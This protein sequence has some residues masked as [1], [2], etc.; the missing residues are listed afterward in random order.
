MTSVVNQKKR[1]KRFI[2]R[3]H[4]SFPALYQKMDNSKYLRIQSSLI[5]WQNWS[6]T[7]ELHINKVRQM[8]HLECIFELRTYDGNIE[9][10]RN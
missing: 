8:T 2:S 1:N 3:D 6:N 10:T 7:Y 4:V 9:L 5:E